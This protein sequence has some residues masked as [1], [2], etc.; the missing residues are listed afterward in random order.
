VHHVG[1]TILICYDGR[2]TEHFTILIYYDGR[3][4][5]HFTILICYDARST[6]HF[7]ILIYYDGRSTKHYVCVYPVFK[8]EGTSQHTVSLCNIRLSVQPTISST[9][10]EDVRRTGGKPTSILNRVS[11]QKRVTSFALR[12]LYPAVTTGPTAA[13]D[14]TQMPFLFGLSVM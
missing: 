1:F 2:S 13:Q 7:T 9:T 6:E 10:N 3:S 4:T 8:G 12:P 5:E 14:K 11:R